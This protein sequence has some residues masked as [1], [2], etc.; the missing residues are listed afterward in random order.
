MRH[1]DAVVVNGFDVL[2]VIGAVT[3]TAAALANII[4]VRRDRPRLVVNFGHRKHQGALPQTWLTVLNDGRQPVTLR[5][6]G[7][8]GSEMPVTIKSQ[9]HGEMTAVATYVFPMIDKPVLLDPGE[10]HEGT[11]LIP[12]AVER[13]YH[14]DFPLR[15]FATDARGRKTWGGAGPVSRW[16]LRGGERPPEIHKAQ[17]EPCEKEIKPAR[18]EPWWKLWVRRELRAGDS[19]RPSY[20][21]LKAL[22]GVDD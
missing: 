15:A 14:V 10:M 6:A 2:A 4:A 20:E 3:G 11:A 22:T 9:E 21:E 1:C 17:W 18:V 13:G 16:I 19:G 8:Y 5:E 7:F 12:D